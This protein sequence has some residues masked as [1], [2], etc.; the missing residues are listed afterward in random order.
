MEQGKDIHEFLKSP[1][2]KMLVIYALEGRTT[3]NVQISKI[4]AT[5][6]LANT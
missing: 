1:I 2:A 4:V 6:E 3:V 5:M